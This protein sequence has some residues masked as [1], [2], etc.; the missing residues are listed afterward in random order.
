MQIGASG[1][2]HIDSCPAVPN[3]EDYIDCSGCAMQDE[4]LS[5]ESKELLG[6]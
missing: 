2:E 4:A 3:C 1:Q 6:S 5:G